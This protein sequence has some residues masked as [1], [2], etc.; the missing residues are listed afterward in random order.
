MQGSVVAPA[1]PTITVSDDQLRRAFGPSPIFGGPGSPGV[2]PDECRPRPV[3]LRPSAPTPSRQASESTDVQAELEAM[4]NLSV[5]EL[6]TVF[7]G[8]P[9]P[10]RD[11]SPA[12]LAIIPT[13]P[14]ASP[15]PSPPFDD[16]P[17]K[18]AVVGGRMD[19]W[20]PLPA[21]PP[22]GHHNFYSHA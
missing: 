13:A 20:P 16:S 14:P 17:W 9:T 10:S 18:R 1:N 21:G 22:P 3:L 11:G 2:V 7:K 15:L 5:E 19:Y 12:P 6:L 8:S 4:K